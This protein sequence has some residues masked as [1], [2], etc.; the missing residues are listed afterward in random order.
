MYDFSD[1]GKRKN[2]NRL[3]VGDHIVV[4]MMDCL[5]IKIY[6]QKL[7]KIINKHVVEE[8]IGYLKIDDIR[9][10]MNDSDSNLILV[11]P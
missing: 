7:I 9:K 2:H 1:K 11:T 4:F 8:A 6:F 3:V 10:V 5:V